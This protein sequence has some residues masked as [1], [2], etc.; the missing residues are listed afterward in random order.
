MPRKLWH[1]VLMSQALHP[2]PSAI[3]P[4]RFLYDWQ[5]VE[6]GLPLSTLDEFASY[7]GIPIKELLEVVIPLRTLK[8]RRQRGE[9]LSVDES[10]RL[11]GVARMY[12]L[13]A[14]VYADAAGGRDWLLRPKRRFAGRTAL[15]MLRTKTGEEAVQEA[16]IQID[17]GM[18][19]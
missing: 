8:H 16:L 3:E 11:A 1:N 14:K 19:V 2:A 17:E 18:F 15:S 9:P 4:N 6:K 12:H 13:A 7:S 10:D 5:T